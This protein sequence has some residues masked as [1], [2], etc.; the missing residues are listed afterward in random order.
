MLLHKGDL[1]WRTLMASLL[2]RLYIPGGQPVPE[3]AAVLRG[4]CPPL[5]GQRAAARAAV[6]CPSC[7]VIG[8]HKRRAWQPSWLAQG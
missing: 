8:R 4:S 3:A 5:L 1:K 2:D 7:D 6:C